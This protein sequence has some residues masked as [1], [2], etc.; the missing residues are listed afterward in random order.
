[1]C[2]CVV[3]VMHWPPIQGVSLPMDQGAGIGSSIPQRPSIGQMVWKMDRLSYREWA[4]EN[5]YEI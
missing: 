5:Y 3:P 2:E 4:I 1:M